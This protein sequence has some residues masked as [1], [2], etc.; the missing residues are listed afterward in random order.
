MGVKGDCDYLVL[1]ASKGVD[2][3]SSIGVPQLGSGVEATSEYF[4]AT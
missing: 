3:F 1:V 4:I 2:K